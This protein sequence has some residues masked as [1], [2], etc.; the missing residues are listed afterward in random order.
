MLACLD[1]ADSFQS[2]GSMADRHWKSIKTF[3]KQGSVQDVFN[4][5]INDDLFSLKNDFLDMFY[6]QTC[7]FKINFS[8]E[9]TLRNRTNGNFRYWHASNDVDRILDQPLLI[10]NFSDFE[11]FL[12]K[13]F[14]QDVL[15][16]ARLSRP[17]SS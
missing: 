15:E 7:R 5:Y 8:F 9:F 6:N 14:E 2:F 13:V 10:S 4:F 11:T 16:K 17:N 3:S 1:E 12:N